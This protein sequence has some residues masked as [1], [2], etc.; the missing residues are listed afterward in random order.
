MQFQQLFCF[1]FITS[2]SVTV[3]LLLEVTSIVITLPYNPNTNLLLEIIDE[4]LSKYENY[5]ETRWN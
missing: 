1:V 2:Y 4:N 3:K 5:Q